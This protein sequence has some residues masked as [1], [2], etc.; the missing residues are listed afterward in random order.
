VAQVLESVVVDAAA[1]TLQTDRGDVSAQ[2]NK[3]EIAN[4]PIDGG[5]NYQSL[6]KLIPGIR[7]KA[8]DDNQE[9]DERIVPV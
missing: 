8:Q 6:L 4:L 7:V 2:I 3:E 5:R 9:I 1:V